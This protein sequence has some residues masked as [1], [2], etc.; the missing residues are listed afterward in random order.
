PRGAVAAALQY[1]HVHV[2]ITQ[3][4]AGSYASG[5]PDEYAFEDFLGRL[6]RLREDERQLRAGEHVSG[7]AAE[8]YRSRVTSSATTRFGGRTIPTE[9]QARAALKHMALQVFPG[10]AMT[11]V[12]DPTQALCQ[13]REPNDDARRTPDLDNCRSA[14]RNI[15][16]TDRDVA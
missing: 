14:C 10:R 12:L 2:R 13:L 6:N 8:T 11:C 9:R 15:A 1:G 7:P 4:Y 3:G 5:F 16:R